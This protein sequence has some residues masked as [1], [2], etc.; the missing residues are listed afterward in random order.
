MKTREMHVFRRLDAQVRQIQVGLVVLKGA[1]QLVHIVVAVLFVV[2][3]LFVVAVPIYVL[4]LVRCLRLQS[5]SCVAGGRC[6]IGGA[7]T[8]CTFLVIGGKP[9]RS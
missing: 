2:A 4:T 6:T 9:R 1:H 5:L 3:M 8:T 7:P